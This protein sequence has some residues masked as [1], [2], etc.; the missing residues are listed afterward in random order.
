MTA[1]EFIA[2]YRIVSTTGRC[3]DRA[4]LLNATTRCWLARGT[5]LHRRELAAVIDDDAF[6]RPH[7]GEVPA[8]VAE[9]V[10]LEALVRRGS[11]S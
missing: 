1:E 8:R 3:Y 9:A 2:R 5:K 11:R 10:Y 6:L 7:G 4:M